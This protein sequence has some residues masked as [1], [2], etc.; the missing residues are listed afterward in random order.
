MTMEN[1]TGEFNKL[2]SQ[3]RLGRNLALLYCLI[4][5]VIAILIF[6]ETA[7]SVP[8][9]LGGLA[10]LWSFISHLSIE[11]PDHAMSLVQLQKKIGNFRIHTAT[12]AKYD[13]L[14]VAL[15][16]LTLA[17]IFLKYTHNISLYSDL[18]A[19][20]V[21]CVISVVVLAFMVAVSRKMYQKNELKLRNTEAY[22]AE[23]IEFEKG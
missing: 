19:L 22:L 16:L 8:A 15:W 12:H 4:S 21:F 11:K 6:E 18:K 7:Y 23:L 14:I 17:P 3:S 5:V 9:I 13:I 2:L 1:A 10:M 20:A